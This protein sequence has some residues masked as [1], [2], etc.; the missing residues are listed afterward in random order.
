MDAGAKAHYSWPTWPATVSVASY[1]GCI[2]EKC[3][4]P[5][6]QPGYETTLFHYSQLY[7]TRT[8]LCI[9]LPSILCIHLVYLTVYLCIL[10]WDETTLLAGWRGRGHFLF[11]WSWLAKMALHV[12]IVLGTSKSLLSLVWVGGMKGECVWGVCVRVCVCEGVCMRDVCDCYLFFLPVTGS[13]RGVWF[14]VTMV[15]WAPLSIM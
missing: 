7:T 9:P 5:P 13:A 12:P 14:P 10:L 1:P 15:L 4:C 6:T 2:E 8:I 11:S 3:F